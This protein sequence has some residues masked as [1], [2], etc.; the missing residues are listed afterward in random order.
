MMLHVNTGHITPIQ[1]IGQLRW[2]PRLSGWAV[3]VNPETPNTVATFSKN[4]GIT[5]KKGDPVLIVRRDQGIHSDVWAFEPYSSDEAHG[6]AA[7]IFEEALLG[8][9]GWKPV[10]PIT[11]RNWQRL[12]ADHQRWATD[13]KQRPAAYVTLTSHRLVA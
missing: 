10:W 11:S 8:F 1:R 3:A 7:D 12:H 2:S 6:F 5:L 13:T 9:D 4:T